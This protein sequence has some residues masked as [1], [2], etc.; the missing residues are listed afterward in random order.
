MAD[1]TQLPLGTQDGS[2]Y[3]DDVISD[4]GVANGARTQRVKVGHGTDG[5]YK[6]TSATDPLPVTAATLPL[7]AGAATEATLAGI[8]TG[9]DKIPASPAQEHTAAASPSS[10]RLSDGAAFYKATTPADTQPVSAASLPL[11]TGAATAALQTQPGVDI[12]DVTV[13]NAAG[14]AA[15]NIQDGGN[16]LTIDAT[17]LPLPTGASTLAEQQTQ[18]TS[19]QLADDVV[20]AA[21]A[22]LSK[23]TA[24]GAQMDDASTVVATENNVSALRMDTNR[25]LHVQLRTG[26]TEAGTAG[27]PLRTD[28]TGT[29]TQPTQGTETLV[30]NA[31]F[32]DGTTRVGMAGYIFDEVAGTALT[33]NDAAAARIDS[34]RAQVGVIED[35]T[36]RGQRLA[37]TAANAAKVDGSAVTQPVS[38][39]ATVTV[40]DNASLVDNAAFTDGTTRVVMDGFIFDETAGTGLTENDAAAARI[41]SKRAQVLVLEDAT[42]RG[43]RATVSAAGAVKVD[44]SAVTQPVSGTVAVSGTVPVAGDVAHDG[45]DSGNP[46]KVG[47]Y[48]SNT[49]PTGV[50]L[51]GDRVNAWFTRAGLQCV[52]LR[53]NVGGGIGS[54][55]SVSDNEGSGS[56]IEVA[57]RV[58]VWNGTSFDRVRG[59]T[60]NG[61]DV[62]VT[63]VAGGSIAHD[64][65][66]TTQNPLLVGGYASAAAPADVSADGD[67]TRLWLLRSGATVVSGDVADDGAD[68]GLPIKIGGKAL[69]NSSVKTAVSATGDRVN[70]WFDMNGALMVKQRHDVTYSAIYRLIDSTA[71]QLPLTFTFTA[72]T[73]KQLATIYHTGAST[74]IVRLRRISLIIGTGAAGVFD[75]EIRALSATTAPAT[76]NPAITPRTHDPADGAAEATCLALP[77]TAG[78]LVGADTG[79]VGTPQTWNS[80][81]ATAHTNPQGLSG[82]ELVLFEA[83]ASRGIK[84]LIMRAATAEGYAING[85]CTAAVA[86][87]YL[88]LFEFT[89]E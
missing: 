69:T 75:F 86:L 16:S 79:T 57:S 8:K 81:A 3:A 73:N 20:H 5:N 24:V 12:G 78:S 7:P 51:D 39:A 61:I 42:T 23:V 44:G 77:T 33:E 48:G 71:G 40:Q 30:D 50:S 17:S 68:A 1:N 41:D 46:I 27:A 43:Q 66:G 67:A 55:A 26:A 35:A 56:H 25:A 22:A 45:V 84:P 63:R 34:K 9:T 60:T 62:D 83:N 58:T 88:A 11:P 18:T 28:P 31:A 6:D 49:Q 14:A 36:T 37:I 53:D 54:A 52:S 4:G 29:T 70:A 38:I 65:V 72:N 82:Q 87:R 85:R 74:K 21:N 80:G 89:E 76:G 19:L 64:G 47:G 13:N 32:T 59:D 10:A 2:L 15:V